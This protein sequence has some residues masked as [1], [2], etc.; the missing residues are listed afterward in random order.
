M[1]DHPS[2]PQIVQ[3]LRKARTGRPQRIGG[4][5]ERGGRPGLAVRGGGY[6]A[7]DVDAHGVDEFAGVEVA[8]AITSQFGLSPLRSAKQ[9]ASVAEANVPASGAHFNL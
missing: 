8:H 5:V 4:G 3:P 7:P 2:S 6:G 1:Q 9:T